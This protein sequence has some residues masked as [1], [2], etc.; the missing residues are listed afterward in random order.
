MLMQI[1]SPFV[2]TT[3]VVGGP[4]TLFVKSPGTFPSE[5]VAPVQVVVVDPQ[6][7]KYVIVPVPVLCPNTATGDTSS[8][9]TDKRNIEVSTTLTFVI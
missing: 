4:P 2:P 8:N 7:L 9:T 5:A 1:E 6:E 3:A